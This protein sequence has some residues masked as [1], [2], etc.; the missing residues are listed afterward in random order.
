[1]AVGVDVKNSH[2]RTPKFLDYGIFM[3]GMGRMFDL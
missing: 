2:T 1:M 3:G